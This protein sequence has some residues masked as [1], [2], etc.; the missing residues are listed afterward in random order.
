MAN[1]EGTRAVVQDPLAPNAREQRPNH[2]LQIGG[3]QAP[4]TPSAASLT[5]Q[6][7]LTQAL[8]G[9]EGVLAQE[10]EKNKDQWITEGKIAYQSGATEQ[11]MLATGNAFTA[12]GYRTLQARDTV[13]NWFTKQ[14]I[15]IDETDKQVDPQQYQQGLMK[16]RADMLQGITDP[17]ARKVAAAA[18][19]DMSPRLA[20]TQ[21]IKNNEYNRGQRINSFSTMLSSTAP[22]SATASVKQPGQPLAIS[23]VPV[24]AVMQPSARDRDIGIRTILGEAANQG[25]D[26]MAAVA[27]VL[28]NRATDGR[29]PSSIAGVSLQPKQFSAW[30]TGAG[31]NAIPN[32]VKP[33]DPMYE[34]AGAV[35]DAVMSGKHVDPTGGATHYYSPA[36]MSK[37]VAD[38]DQTNS[39]PPWLSAETEKSGGQIKI[40]GHIFVGKANA[41]AV[42]PGVEPA[43]QV[44][45]TTIAAGTAGDVN[46]VPQQEKVGVTGVAQAAGAN[47]VQQLIRGYAGL[48]P[49]DKATAVA[50]AMRRGFDA[51]NN[52]LFHDAGGLSALYSLK[53]KPNEIDE[54]IKAQKRY[55]EKQQTD[56]NV[57]REKYRDDI[58]KRAE[59][60]E[61]IDSIL[62]D[63]DKQHKAGMLNDANARALAQTAADKIRAADKEGSK[64]GNIDMLNELGGLY[65]QVITGGDPKVLAQ[66]ATQIAKKYDATDKDVQHIVGKMFN[67][68]QTY[69]NNL[70]SEAKAAAKT[71]AEQ[72]GIK[73]EVDRK[74]SL[75]NGLSTVTGSVKTVN[76]QGQPVT[77]SAQNYGVQLIH[78]KWAKNVTDA[79]NAGKLEPGKAKPTLET[80]VALELQ[81][82]N[83]VDEKTRDQ[84]QGALAGNIVT[85]DGKLSPEASQAYSTWLNLRTNGD[86]MPSYLAK[87]T[88]DPNVRNLLEHAYLYDGG[89]LSKDQ[90]LVKA[91]EILSDPS[92]DPNDKI[93]KDAVWRQKLDVDMTK[94]LME[95]TH[96]GF[97]NSLFATKDPSERE[98]ILTNDKT[99]KNWVI[100]QAEMYHSMNYREDGAVSLKK[101]LDDLQTNSTPVMG[102]LIITK[103]GNELGK[104]MGVA[105]LGPNAAEDAIS[106][107]VRKNAEKWWPQAYA[108]QQDSLLG[109]RTSGEITSDQFKKTPDGYDRQS[110]IGGVL[111]AM[112]TADKQFSPQGIMRAISSRY[113]NPADLTGS[114]RDAPPVHITYDHSQG[115]MTVDLYKDAA[116]TQTLGSPQHFFVKKVG[117]DYAKEQT[118]PSTTDKLW[119]SMFK[120]AATG[121]KDAA[122][123]S[124]TTGAFDTT[125]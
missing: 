57:G 79:V 53:A 38:G 124:A 58:M 103:P 70:R 92:H 87:L 36:G 91:H 50:D 31:G 54:V 94:T 10:F 16:Q 11:Q 113:E 37:L 74:L 122:N 27:H 101:A 73:G 85:S 30:N 88:P 13:N 61:N 72:D 40:G 33:G 26:G 5:P 51:G 84:L 97:L 41:A 120:G 3:V 42:R 93:A 66:Q 71:K 14:S 64:L 44:T 119:N 104:V 25:D 39:L 83:I 49:E 43:Q 22:T 18:F 32:S 75:G 20:S 107:Y 110:M 45:A 89:T 76:D 121:A 9:V 86:I 123:F 48:N 56:F 105:G 63:I 111:H 80:N 69:Q 100:N 99:A 96:P 24:E 115:I 29:W 47:E 12:Q 65:Q 117:A 77:V 112:G 114:R 46:A 34:K 8:T 55:N 109:G 68:N 59:G 118:T 90:A 7:G 35:F 52:T 23:P 21:Q 28:R 1:T 19:E 95:R 116:M 125:Q 78:D 17:S 108:N 81:N 15:A 2:S 67:D 62:A 98:R 82:H 60:G 102:N 6:D 106:N 4:Q